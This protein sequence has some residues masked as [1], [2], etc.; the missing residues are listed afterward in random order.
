MLCKECTLNFK[1]QYFGK[2][3]KLAFNNRLLSSLVH[4]MWNQ[5]AFVVIPDKPSKTSTENLGDTATQSEKVFKNYT[6]FH[7]KAKS[8][9]GFD[10]RVP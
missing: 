6:H 4:R 2:L 5:L 3:E 7:T 9:Q 1:R 10:L 8:I